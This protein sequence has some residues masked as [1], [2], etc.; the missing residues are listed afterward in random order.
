MDDGEGGLVV[1]EL[2]EAVLEEATQRS[3]WDIADKGKRLAEGRGGETEEQKDQEDG[4]GRLCPPPTD[5][6]S[7]IRERCSDRLLVSYSLRGRGYTE[8]LQL[9]CLE[10][11]ASG[12][13]GHYALHFALCLLEVCQAENETGKLNYLRETNSAGALW[14]RFV[15][16]LDFLFFISSSSTGT[17]GQCASC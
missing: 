1:S 13:C 11:Q 9:K 3:S 6:C 10:Q 14:R 17:G 16:I 7:L 8:L 4:E 5:L 15:T 12:Y 2:L